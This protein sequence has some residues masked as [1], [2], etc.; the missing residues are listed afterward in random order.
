[1]QKANKQTGGQCSMQ[2][3]LVMSEAGPSVAD[4]RLKK[5]ERRMRIQLTAALLWLK[6]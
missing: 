4:F 3:N 2:G 6:S 5:K 1:M